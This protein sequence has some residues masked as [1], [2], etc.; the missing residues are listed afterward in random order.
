MINN[1]DGAERPTVVNEQ[2]VKGASYADS[3]LSQVV[4]FTG[5]RGS[6]K[7]ISMTVQAIIGMAMG[8][9]CWSNYPIEVTVGHEYDK[10]RWNSR[11]LRSEPLSM[12]GLYTLESGIRVGLVCIDE[13]NLWAD[14]RRSLA[15]TNQLLSYVFQ[16]IRKRQLSFY[17]TVQ[18]FLW[19]DSRLRWQ[20]DA[21]IAC[22]DL[23]YRY[24]NLPKGFVIGQQLQDR[25]GFYTGHPYEQSGR[26][27]TR[28]LHARPFWGTYDTNREFDVLAAAGT[29]YEI[30]GEKRAIVTGEDGES[31][32]GGKGR[33]TEIVAY[34]RTLVADMRRDGATKAAANLL[35][36]YV[37]EV[38]PGES[39][40]SLGRHFK[41]AGLTYRQGRGR[42]DYDFPEE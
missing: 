3:E 22:E 9:R 4:V 28:Q 29:K 16:L 7:T 39:N 19:L 33:E 30:I 17:L 8:L 35:Q 25:S 15:V 38:F 34:I 11:L 5:G 21:L 36:D 10:G 24:R 37:R 32:V 1:M 23:H 40:K 12:E 27:Y 42:A 26:I 6:G 18:N 14:S 13:I 41:Q 2:D 20:T 31:Y